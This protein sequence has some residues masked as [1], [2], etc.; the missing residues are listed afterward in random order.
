MFFHPIKNEVYPVFLPAVVHHVFGTIVQLHADASAERNARHA[1]FC[2]SHSELYL[3]W[4]REYGD[5]DT[6]R[7]CSP[8]SCVVVH[9]ASQ[10]D[11][12][13]NSMMVQ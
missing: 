9:L 4:I 8:T 11:G 5:M 7:F 2:W 1:V 3:I 6:V 12:D 13:G 10:N